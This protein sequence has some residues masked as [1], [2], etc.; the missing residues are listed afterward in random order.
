MATE[1]PT[2]RHEVLRLL[3]EAPF[4]AGAC[5][6]GWQTALYSRAEYALAEVVRHVQDA[7]DRPAVEGRTPQSDAAP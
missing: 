6:C 4:W 5:A 1:D 2:R 7:R 3:G